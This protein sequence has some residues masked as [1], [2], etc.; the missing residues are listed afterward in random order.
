MVLGRDMGPRDRQVG[1]VYNQSRVRAFGSPWLCISGKQD[2]WPFSLHLFT[3]GSRTC[4]IWCRWFQFTS[5]LPWENTLK[6]K[7]WV[8]LHRKRRI[9][10]LLLFSYLYHYLEWRCR[11]T[12]FTVYTRVTVSVFTFWLRSAG[13]NV[14]IV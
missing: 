10:F 12:W 1:R 7:R 2:S 5:R 4:Q 6:R 9:T 11:I 3:K 13:L 8:S 14:P